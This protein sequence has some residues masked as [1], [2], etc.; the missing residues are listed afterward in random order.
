MLGSRVA[1]GA[2]RSCGCLK[3]AALSK[4]R[5]ASGR[6]NGN[7]IHGGTRRSE[8]IIWVGMRRRCFNPKNNRF[9]QY[10]ARGITVCERWH[11]FENFLADMGPRPSAEHSIDRIDNDGDYEPGNCRWATRSE[12]MRNRKR[13][14]ATAGAGRAGGAT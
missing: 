4:G 1:R 3:R 8:F 13:R 12:Q 6:K 11:A 2:A 5:G 14:D 9:Q 7:F 10:G